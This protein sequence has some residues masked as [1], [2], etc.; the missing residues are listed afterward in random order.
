MCIKI[1][2]DITVLGNLRMS[3]EFVGLGNPLRSLDVLGSSRKS[4]EV[5][6]CVLRVYKEITVIGS[7]RRS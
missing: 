1:L 3:Y 7:P 2:K 5:L 4:S 6:G